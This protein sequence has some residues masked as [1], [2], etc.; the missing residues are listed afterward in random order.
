MLE[1]ED[2]TYSDT[3]VDTTTSYQYII[4]VV[5]SDADEIKEEAIEALAASEDY[6]NDDGL[7]ID[8]EAF[9][10]YLNKLGY[11]IH[12]V[13]IYEDLLSDSYM[14]EED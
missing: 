4:Y 11:S 10:Y 3:V 14:Y 9:N 8:E 13:E 6:T 1:T 5:S 2:G 7:S 12:D